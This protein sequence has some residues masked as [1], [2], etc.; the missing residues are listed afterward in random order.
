VDEARQAG[1]QIYRRPPGAARLSDWSRYGSETGKAQ[2]LHHLFDDMAARGTLTHMAQSSVLALWQ[3]RAQI[4][5]PDGLRWERFDRLILATGATDR[6]FPV[7]GWQAAG[8][9]SLGAMQI[10]LKSQAVALG[11]RIVLAGSGPL[12]TLLAAQLIK[13][14]AEVAAVLDTSPLRA[15]AR[16]FALM[17]TARPR[18]A[19]RGVALRVRL[20]RLYKAGVQDLRIETGEHGAAGVHWHDSGW[21]AHTTQCDAV[22]LGWHL[23]ADLALADLAGARFVWSRAWEQWLPHADAEGRVAPKV[24]MAGD[25]LDILGA[26]GA[27]AA[28]TLVATTCLRDMGLPTGPVPSLA[29]HKRFAKGVS[30]AFPGPAALMAQ[31]EDATIAC[32]CEGVRAAEIRDCA[33]R[34]G[35]DINRVKS[36]CR[37]GMGRCQG[38][39]CQGATARLIAAQT[40]ASMSEVGRL[41]A[42]PPLRPLPVSAVVQQNSDETVQ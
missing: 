8:V 27:E 21:R 14:G 37:A 12:L 23:Q 4:L 9:Y 17:A 29:R 28:G 26:D 10:A 15:Q 40:G 19:L 7:P 6:L 5:T 35:P 41:R 16:G 34:V 13:A 33:A 39:Y 32:R 11:K 36:Q 31:T 30:L 18:V 42:Q 2:R 24:Y 3:D 22:G 25:G 38:R 20:G 1:G